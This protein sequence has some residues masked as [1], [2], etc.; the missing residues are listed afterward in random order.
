MMFFLGGGAEILWKTASLR[1]LLQEIQII[2][3]LGNFYTS[4]EFDFTTLFQTPLL[5][6]KVG[7]WSA[8]SIRQCVSD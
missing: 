1:D 8:V 7:P 6:F 2:I 3:V 5:I 4:P